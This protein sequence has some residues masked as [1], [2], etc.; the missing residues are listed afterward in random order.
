M[1]Y[2]RYEMDTCHVIFAIQLQIGID[3]CNELLA[4]LPLALS[5]T[6]TLCCI[7]CAIGDS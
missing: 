1:K 3:S 4:L 6:G 5:K 2:M 7:S